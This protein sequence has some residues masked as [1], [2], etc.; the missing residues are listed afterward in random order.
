MDTRAWRG[1]RPLHADHVVV[2]MYVRTQVTAQGRWDGDVPMCGKRVLQ[3]EEL[4]VS[5][6]GGNRGPN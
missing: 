4:S 1:S 2:R 3:Q 6:D 5:D